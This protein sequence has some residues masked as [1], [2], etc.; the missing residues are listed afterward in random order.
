MNILIDN[1]LMQFFHVPNCT[2][3]LSKKISY[4]YFVVVFCP[5]LDSFLSENILYFIA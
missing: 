1:L 2:M 5:A 3:R 4:Q